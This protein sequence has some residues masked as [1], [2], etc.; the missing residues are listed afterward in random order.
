MQRGKPVEIGLHPV[1]QRFIGRIHVGEQRV[2]AARRALLDV[3]DRA[4]RRLEVAGHVGV[5]ALAIGARRI[6]VGIDLHQRRIVALMG[7]GGMDVQFAELAAEGEMLLR[8]DVLVAEE[9]HEIFGERA[10]DLVHGPVGAASRCEIDAGYLRADDRGELFDADGLVR[11]GPRRRCADSADLA[12]WRA[13]TWRF[14]RSMAFRRIVARMQRSA[15]RDR[16][17]LGEDRSRIAHLADAL[18]RSGLRASTPP[19]SP[20][21]REPSPPSP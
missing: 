15:I 2:A 16:L 13:R 1:R 12:C 17:D 4:H 11:L 9:D 21:S 3:E 19:R 18:A 20:R 7:R 14:L 10:M 5:P 6:L 8:R